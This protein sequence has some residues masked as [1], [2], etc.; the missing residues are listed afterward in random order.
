[1]LASIRSKT[2]GAAVLCCRERR[3]AE[4]LLT[5]S[6]PKRKGKEIA[7]VRIYKADQFV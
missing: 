3:D 5:V 7:V 1:M 4:A 6:K 2:G